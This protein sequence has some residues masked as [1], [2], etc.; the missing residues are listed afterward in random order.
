MRV[1]E[2]LK[3]SCVLTVLPF[4]PATALAQDAALEK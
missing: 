1:A 3:T 2:R 4:L